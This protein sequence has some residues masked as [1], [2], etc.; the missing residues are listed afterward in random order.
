MFVY[1]TER[2]VRKKYV[3]KQKCQVQSV[4]LKKLNLFCC[5]GWFFSHS[6]KTCVNQS[7]Q[8]CVAINMYWNH[9]SILLVPN[10][11]ARRKVW[12][13]WSYLLL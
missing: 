9:A 10:Y 12:L 13:F 5:F 1:E 8:I 6:A 2:E 7:I 4:V 11:S 3:L